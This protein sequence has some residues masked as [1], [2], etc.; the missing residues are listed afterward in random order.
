[1]EAFCREELKWADRRQCAVLIAV[2]LSL[3]VF[4]CWDNV[5]VVQAWLGQA[6]C[7]GPADS[8]NH[9]QARWWFW[10]LIEDGAGFQE[11]A[12]YAHWTNGNCSVITGRGGEADMMQPVI[13]WDGQAVGGWQMWLRADLTDGASIL[14][15]VQGHL[16]EKADERATGDVL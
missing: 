6:G 10:D 7:L 16:C 14:P 3:S 1:M 12:V 8:R 11:R 4:L 9:P 2:F 15:Q 13:R 5:I